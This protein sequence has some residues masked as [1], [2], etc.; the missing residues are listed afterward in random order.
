MPI[1]FV[2]NYLTPNQAALFSRSTDVIITYSQLEERRKWAPLK[3]TAQ[4][5]DLSRLHL[6]RRLYE[7]SCELNKSFDGTLIGGSSRSPEFWFSIMLCRLQR[8]L[9][10]I[11]MERPRV[12]V[13]RLRSNVLRLALGKAGGI[14]AVGTTATTSY[15]HLIRGVKVQNFPYTYGRDLSY[16]DEL[17]HPAVQP[18]DRRI[19]ALFIGAEWERKGLDILLSAVTVMPRELQSRLALRVAGLEALPSELEGI[20]GIAPSADITY[21]GFLQPNDLR[22]EMSSADV[23]VVPSRYDGWAVVVEEAMAEGTPV[24]ASDEVG[25]AADLVVDG[26]SGFIFPSEDSEALATALA[27]VMCYGF[28]DRSLSVGAIAIVAQ[29][30]DEYNIQSLEQAICSS[31]RL[32]GFGCWRRA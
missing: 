7:I 9:F 4:V 18:T 17:D 14:L 29:H 21:L 6:W 13:T 28:S 11:W 23:L 22:R 2:T 20:F 10:S 8:R 16:G 32:S 31:P 3:A 30:R 26:C 5:K 27:A 24:I 19:T 25:A 12:P 15:R 1:V